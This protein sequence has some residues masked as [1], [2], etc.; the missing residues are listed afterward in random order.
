MTN[1]LEPRKELDEKDFIQD[2]LSKNPFPF[3]LWLVLLT[4]FLG[5]VW[6]GMSWYNS[7]MTKEISQSPFLQVTNRD[8]SVF[9]WQFPER[10]RA[11]YYG[12]KRGY[13][14]GFQ[15]ENKVSLFLEEADAYVS[16]PP[17]L[18]FLYHTWDRLIKDEYTPRPI[19]SEEFKE[20]LNYSEEWK[21]I[22]WKNAPVGYKSLV[23]QLFKKS[24]QQD[25]NL[26]PDTELPVQVRQAFQGWKN[27]IKEGKEIDATRP[28]YAQVREFLK[29][30]PHYTRNYWE[31][32]V[33]NSSPDYLKN[34][35]NSNVKEDAEIPKIELSPFLH[36]ALFN[37]LKSLKKE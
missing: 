7:L 13:L 23:D 19:P 25:I 3:W 16:A 10:M 4:T 9:L 11:N 6:G 33:V 22:N 26:L 2:S 34:I 28:T 36:V 8:F 18:L 15:Y 14:P 35:N 27:Y 31:N 24:E 5:L 12:T 17:E 1:N 32:I 30:H 29:G 21:P 37:Y 20:F